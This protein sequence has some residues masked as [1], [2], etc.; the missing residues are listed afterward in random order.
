[1]AQDVFT[2]DPTIEDDA[3]LMATSRDWELPRQSDATGIDERWVSSFLA[4]R[5]ADLLAQHVTGERLKRLSPASR[6]WLK[7]QCEQLVEDALV[8]FQDFDGTTA[9]KVLWHEHS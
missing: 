1:M 3:L 5:F 6:A 7:G 8:K 4:L 9:P 2:V